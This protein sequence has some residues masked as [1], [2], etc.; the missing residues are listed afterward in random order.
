MNDEL[1]ETNQYK[2]NTIY[3]KGTWSFINL[4]LLNFIILI[5]ATTQSLSDH[6]IW[7]ICV[8]QSQIIYFLDY[9]HQ[10]FPWLMHLFSFNCKM[11][12]LTVSSWF[13][14]N[15][16]KNQVALSWLVLCKM[17]SFYWVFLG[18]RLKGIAYYKNLRREWWAKS[19]A[20]AIS[21]SKR[22]VGN[23]N[24]TNWHQEATGEI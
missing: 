7:L 22:P 13:Y 10:Y 19:R 5:I 8:S 6:T 16:S 2:F 9:F 18:M 11:E 20:S 12:S 21:M 14:I 4:A 15:S 17:T 1:K 23:I 24:M 3:F